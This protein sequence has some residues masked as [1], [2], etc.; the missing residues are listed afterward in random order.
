[1]PTFQDPVVDGEEACQALRALAHA[2][3]S[4][5]QPTETYV[6]VGDV[7]GGLRSL[8][9]VLDQLASAHTSENAI[10][11]AEGGDHGAGIEEA[12][13]AATAL[14]RAAALVARAELAV[15]RASRHSGRIVWGPATSNALLP[16]T[17]RIAPRI[18]ADDSFLRTSPFCSPG[19]RSSRRRR[20]GM[21][22]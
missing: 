7:L 5:D 4:F 17:E 22:L 2:T 16:L 3:R 10:P 11:R 13:A 1:M 14:R 9:Q 12:Y 8:G 15:D 6:V 18:N 21:S 20:N 19:S